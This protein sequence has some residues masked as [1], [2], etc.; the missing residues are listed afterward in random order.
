METIEIDLAEYP[1]EVLEML[2]VESCKQNLPVNDIIVDALSRL[3]KHF[4]SL[5]ANAS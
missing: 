1:R 3:V 4:D 2:I 5:S